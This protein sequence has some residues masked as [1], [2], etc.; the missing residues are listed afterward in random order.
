[1]VGRFHSYLQSALVII[2][3]YRGE[4][5][6]HLFLKAYF[7]QH[8][9]YGSKDR[10]Q[11][12]HLC[13]C[14]YRSGLAMRSMETE[15]KL[16]ASLFLC[17]ATEDPLLAHF[18][19]EWMAMVSRPVEDKVRFLQ[20]KQVAINVS[21]I[22]PLSSHLSPSLSHPHIFTLSHYKQPN[23]FVRIRPG[24]ETLVR[25]TLTEHAIPFN[26]EDHCVELPNGADVTGLLVADKEIVVQDLSSQRTGLIIR[27]ALEAAGKAP[28]IW[29]CCAASG[30][31]SML[32][33][34]INPSIDLTVSDIRSSIL[35]NLEDRFQKAGIR[36]FRAFETDLTVPMRPGKKYDIVMADVPCSGSGTWGRTPADMQAFT[37]E[38]LQF[39]Q[40]LQRRIL[41]NLLSSI[42]PGGQL[43][44]FTCSVYAEENEAQVKF[45]Q[46]NSFLELQEMSLLEGYTRGA[47]TLFAARFILPA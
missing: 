43:L 46:E 7:R 19:P 10:K 20:E 4:Q 42:K 21:E 18:R 34:D 32:A 14:F 37:L 26:M 29:D 30:G 38:R 22:F 41:T 25:Q 13:Y 28:S 23:L 8:P 35:D 44:Y 16:L 2:A 17:T 11:V 15:D 31:K 1:M 33:F 5:P 36:Q 45:I 40:Q 9:K 12:A 3:Q 39:Y 47:D 27:H 24:K 6:F